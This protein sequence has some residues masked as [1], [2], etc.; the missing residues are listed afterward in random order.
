MNQ[1]LLKI[2]TYI[3]TWCDEAF[4]KVSLYAHTQNQQQADM[5]MA[6]LADLQWIEVKVSRYKT[7]YHEIVGTHTHKSHCPLADPLPNFF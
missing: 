3:I 5:F 1:S 2:F 6:L 7:G 4:V